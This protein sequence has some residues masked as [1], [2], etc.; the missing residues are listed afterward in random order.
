MSVNFLEQ[1]ASGLPS[2][3][4]TAARP[5]RKKAAVDKT[6][7]EQREAA[8]ASMDEILKNMVVRSSRGCVQRQQRT[9]VGLGVYGTEIIRNGMAEYGVL[10]GNGLVMAPGKEIET[11]DLGEGVIIAGCGALFLR[12]YRL[13]H[14]W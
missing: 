2:A 7:S 13:S 14:E 10:N 4:A 1:E 6:R 3:S 9:G 11:F 8:L 5:G 12:K